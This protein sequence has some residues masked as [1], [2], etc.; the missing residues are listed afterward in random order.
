M[1]QTRHEVIS[2]LE[3]VQDQPGPSSR[4]LLLV[5]RT[6][7]DPDGDPFRPG[8]LS[9]LEVR[10]QLT[11]LLRTLADRSRRLLV[12][13]YVQGRPATEI[14]RDLGISRVHCYRLRNKAL[15][16]I[17]EAGAHRSR[18]ARRAS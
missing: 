8:F 5:D 6:P 13:W 1:L 15:D 3:N 2:A 4:S 17:I 11:D 12:L 18:S 7:R 14:A 9:A 10:D 16:E